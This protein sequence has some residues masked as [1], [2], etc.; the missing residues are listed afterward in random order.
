LEK[1][2][3]QSV[4]CLSGPKTWF[5]IHFLNAYSNSLS[6]PDHSLPL[7]NLLKADHSPPLDFSPARAENLLR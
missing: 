5:L 7:E 6:T 2:R 4:L 1:H 3:P